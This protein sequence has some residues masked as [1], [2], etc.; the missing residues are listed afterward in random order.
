MM[1]YEKYIR[2]TYYILSVFSCFSFKNLE[3]FVS[4]Y[5]KFDQSLGSV[6]LHNPDK[7]RMR[8]QNVN[9]KI[10]SQNQGHELS[11]S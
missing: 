4:Q 7:E 2:N 1:N 11:S 3:P 6:E 8:K 5:L 10:N 9:F